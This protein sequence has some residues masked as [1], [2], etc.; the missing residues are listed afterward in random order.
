MNDLSASVKT[1]KSPFVNIR[2][3]WWF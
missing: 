3:I 2:L 1:L